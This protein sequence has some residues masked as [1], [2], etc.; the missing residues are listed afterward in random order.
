MHTS[1]KHTSKTLIRHGCFIEEALLQHWR[2][3]KY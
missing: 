3:M 1:N 2:G